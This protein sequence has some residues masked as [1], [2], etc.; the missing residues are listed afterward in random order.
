M[1]TLFNICFKIIFV[2]FGNVVLKPKDNLF[3]N[4][5]V[6]IYRERIV[7]CDEARASLNTKIDN[8]V[9]IIGNENRWRNIIRE[10]ITA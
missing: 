10:K 1:P 5:L 3:I 8:A 2:Y 7:Q 9:Y 4:L 6:R